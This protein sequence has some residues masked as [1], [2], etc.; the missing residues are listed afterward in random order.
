MIL[1]NRILEFDIK[2]AGVTILYQDGY[3]SETLYQKFIHLEKKERVVQNGLLIKE[4]P[5]YYNIQ[6]EGYKKYI[7]KFIE[8]N[9]IKPQNILSIIKD[10]VWI[11]GRDPNKLHFD[12]I[13]FV[14]KRVATS[15]Y[16]F[17]NIFFYVNSFSDEMFVRGLNT[18]I[19]HPFMELL[20]EILIYNEYSTDLYNKLHTCRYNLLEKEDYYG[21]PI[22]VNIKNLDIINDLIKI[23]L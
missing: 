5:E 18:S 17:K 4:H 10:A 6:I 11:I 14:R 7:N 3:I 2:N 15:M 22:G 19:D 12:K 20:K 23:I 21:S 16:K 8:E 1:I 13:E 9:K